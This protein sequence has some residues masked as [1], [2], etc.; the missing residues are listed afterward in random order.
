LTTNTS[1]RIAQGAIY[2]KVKRLQELTPA[3]AMP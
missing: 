2:P 3:S 1:Q